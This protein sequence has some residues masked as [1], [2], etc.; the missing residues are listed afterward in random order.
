MLALLFIGLG[1][2][3]YA[4]TRDKYAPTQRGSVVSPAPAPLDKPAPAV[5]TP[6]RSPES[7]KPA[8]KSLAAPAAP[9]PLPRYPVGL[10]MRFDGKKATVKKA[11][12]DGQGGWHFLVDIDAGF[13]LKIK[14]KAVSEQFI[15]DTLSA[16][17]KQTLGPEQAFPLGVEVYRNG[18]GGMIEAVSRNPEG[19]YVYRVKGWENLVT[20]GQF[21][22]ELVK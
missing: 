7:P 15:R 1:V 12:Q 9:L 14:D 16:Q 4:L 21:L 18:K 5:M 13:F 19:I 11:W 6:T 20:Q 10:E 22:D 2:V 3:A 8:P 17:L